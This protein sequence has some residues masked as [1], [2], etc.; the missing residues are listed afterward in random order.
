M[1]KGGFCG[2]DRVID[3]IDYVVEDEKDAED[4]KGWL[5]RKSKERFAKEHQRKI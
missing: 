3:I 2:I 5:D 4:L 1:K